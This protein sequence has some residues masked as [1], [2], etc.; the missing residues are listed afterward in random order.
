MGTVRGAGR[1]IGACREAEAR[2]GGDGD[3]DEG[4]ERADRG[5]RA[6][7][8]AAVRYGT[9]AGISDP[10]VAGSSQSTSPLA[11]DK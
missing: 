4:I 5:E 11:T 8:P 6:E 3:H 10:P 9:G 7:V 2:D 1:K